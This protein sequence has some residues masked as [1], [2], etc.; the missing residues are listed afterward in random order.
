MARPYSTPRYPGAPHPTPRSTGKIP[1]APIHNPY[2]K[3]TQP[4]FDAWIGD[5]TGALKRALGRE[6]APSLSSTVKREQ[7]SEEEEEEEE[8]DGGV[9]DSFA[10]VRARRLAKGKERAR[11]DDLADEV[12][13]SQQI[14]ED[15]WDEPIHGE[16]FGSYSEE[17]E[18]DEEVL[19]QREAEVIDL[20]SDDDEETQG[21]EQDEAG[22]DEK[23]GDEDE[24]PAVAD[25]EEIEGS[26]IGS[27]EDS[28]QQ[29]PFE[30]DEEDE[31]GS[32]ARSD[33]EDE[34]RQSSPVV[35]DVTEIL[36]SDEEPEEQ[37]EPIPERRAIPARILRKPDVVASA[38]STDYE[39]E[40][41]EEDETQAEEEADPF[42][43]RTQQQDEV[44]IQDPWR[45]PRVF[46]EDFYS[47]GDVPATAL[48]RGD[49]HILPGEEDAEELQRDRS[50]SPPE[51]EDPWEGPRIFA[52]DFYAG[53]DALSQSTDGLVPPLLTPRDEGELFIPGISPAEEYAHPAPDDSQVVDMD[54]LYAGIDGVSQDPP[55]GGDEDGVVEDETAER[56]PSPA[57]STLITE[58]NWNWPPAFPGKVAVGAGR[59]APEENEIIAI[60]DDEDE[61]PRQAVAEGNGVAAF[62]DSPSAS[63]GMGPVSFYPDFD[64]Y[65]VGPS[66]LSDDG[67]GAFE[68][69]LNG[70]DFGDLPPSRGEI[71]QD[72]ENDEPAA[73]VPSVG[74]TEVGADISLEYEGVDADQQLPPPK[75]GADDEPIVEEAENEDARLPSVEDQLEV[76]SVPAE[77]VDISLSNY[78]VEEA[79]TEGRLTEEPESSPLKE[80]VEEQPVPQLASADASHLRLSIDVDTII[81]FPA[82]VSADP[83]VP[84]PASIAPTPTSPKARSRSRSPID[85]IASS[86]GEV[87]EPASGP[88]HAL[89]PVFRKIG[90]AHS[91][92]GLFT[93]LTN[94]NSG[95][96]TP[97][98]QQ[99]EAELKGET[100]TVAVEQ[101]EEPKTVSEEVLPAVEVT[102]AVDEINDA[103]GEL[104]DVDDNGDLIP[105]ESLAAPET[106]SA[107][108]DPGVDP[109]ETPDDLSSLLL[110]HEDA[111]PES[112]AD[113]DRE[114][115]ASIDD[116]A[117]AEG[118]DDPDY[119]PSEGEAADDSSVAPA[120]DIVASEVAK[121]AEEVME[122]G[123]PVQGE[124]EAEAVEEDAAAAESVVETLPTVEELPTEELPTEELPT[125]ELLTEELPTEELPTEELPTEEEQTLQVDDVAEVEQ[126]EVAIPF[127]P[128]DRDDPFESKEN[129]GS[130]LST[131]QKSELTVNGRADAAKEVEDSDTQTELAP[132]QE[133]VVDESRD[134]M[135]PLKRK[136][137]S[138]PAVEKPTRQLRPRTTKSTDTAR[139]AKSTAAE[140]KSKGKGKQRA[141]EESDDEDAAS[142]AHS[143]VSEETSG[144]GS[145]S[146]AA[147]RLL[148][149][150][151]RTTSRASSVVSNAPSTYSAFSLPSPTI[152]RMMNGDHHAPAPVPFVHEHGVLRHRHGAPPVVSVLPPPVRRQPSKPPSVSDASASA[153]GSPEAGTPSDASGRSQRASAEPAPTPP[154]ASQ[155]SRAARSSPHSRP[156]VAASTSSPVTR[157]NCRY[158]TISLPRDGTGHPIFFAVP[159]CSLGNGEL[160]KEESIQ[161]HGDVNARDIPKLVPNVE[162]LNLSPYLIGILRRLVGVDLLREHEVLYLPRDGDGV[163]VKKNRTLLY[164]AHS[165]QVES[166]SAAQRESISARTLSNGGLSR[167]S[168]K[169]LGKT[170]SMPPPSQASASTSGGSSSHAGKLSERGSVASGGSIS[171]SDLS[172]LD[173]DR[174]EEDMPARKR[175][176][177]SPREAE[178]EPEA[179]TTPVDPEPGP[180][181]QPEGESSQGPAENGN[182]SASASKARRRQPR[183]SRKLGTDAAAY[184]PES[185]ESDGSG[186]EE[187]NAEGS[188]KRKRG[189]RKGG[190]K[191]TRT[192]EVPGAATA[193]GR[194]KRRRVRAAE[195]AAAGAGAEGGEHA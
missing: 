67:Q 7:R 150:A 159:G 73:P 158:H 120:E 21:P 64:L 110:P 194:S 89:L 20:L 192:E 44:D 4:E 51:V 117:D 75:A 69:V 24:G 88:A 170:A 53:G 142:V 2:D 160:M 140:S 123:K 52:E 164:R 50:S 146:T 16:E 14:D 161:D 29:A 183:R 74:Q 126:P 60:S 32:E 128:V 139:A 10:E 27:D 38:R 127:S 76:A 167:R 168:R 91:P 105:C 45:G 68:P 78:L 11:V 163:T 33:D 41:A 135:R 57:P 82:P 182:G 94:G 149:P 23:E 13:D 5:I 35:H 70:N 172:D 99:G 156:S 122:F 106:V 112:T 185:G 145:S 107:A 34:A 184:K 116:D 180:Q 72:D 3:F 81:E 165:S 83:T 151:S 175:V 144:S 114:Q 148:I 162:D 9:E 18:D 79:M 58:V 171:G 129:I 1:R 55:A 26:E 137:R 166:I 179:A 155:S 193:E 98:L 77:E 153:S 49:P 39:D 189:G 17:E 169:G 143:A 43:P 48:E 121:E 191:R 190:L 54:D 36:D 113:A 22:Q 19:E 104:L 85:S 86:S 8:E 132:S 103:S 141:R 40:D 101:F 178:Q 42:P 157:A 177:G 174:D 46:A 133:T 100:P 47:G 187:E 95:S 61:E 6:D 109:T 59:L 80:A 37:P 134:G 195:K 136:R 118:E 115:A 12:D 25:E 71:L 147:Q 63:A 125:E 176:K 96:V 138:P 124:A 93:P 119:V 186:D 92:S 102:E 181:S 31:A 130:S 173:D 188:K 66:H 87:N 111:I 154:Q 131:S 62:P 108:S 28:V 65:N 15:V 30:G 56:D 152:M 97:E 84:D 90:A